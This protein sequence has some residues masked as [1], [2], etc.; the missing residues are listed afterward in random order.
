MAGHPAG[1]RVDRVLDGDAVRLEQLGHLA[2]RV[3]ALADG[4]AVAGDDH[5]LRGVGE[6]DR[7]VGGARRA[8]G[9]VAA[10]AAA[11]GSSPRRRSRRR[12]SSGS[13]GSSPPPSAAS[14]ACPTR[15]RSCPRRSAPVLSIA[16]PVAA[17]DRPVKAFSSEITTGMSAP[18]IGSTSIMP[19]AAAPTSRATNSSSLV[20]AGDDRRRAADRDRRQQGVERHLQPADGDRVAGDQ[21]LELRERDVEPQNETLPTIAANTLKIA[22]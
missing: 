12:R 8:D 18:P 20:A 6:L 10:A 9:A 5:D 16:T 14:A 4:E 19:S 7:D 13:S 15:R 17:A 22:T 11:A 3:L 2:H 21:P 1:D